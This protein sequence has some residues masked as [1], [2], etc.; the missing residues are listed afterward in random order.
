ML[1]YLSFPLHTFCQNPRFSIF[2][3]QSV[4]TTVDSHNCESFILNWVCCQSHDIDL[5]LILMVHK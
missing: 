4:L 5:L 2:Y 1:C 3:S